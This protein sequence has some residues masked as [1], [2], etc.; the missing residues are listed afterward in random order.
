MQIESQFTIKELSPLFPK[1][2]IYFEKSQLAL[3]HRRSADFALVKPLAKAI[4]IVRDQ[5][6][7]QGAR[8]QR[9][10][11]RIHPEPLQ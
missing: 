9:T 7:G 4:T 5:S 6:H 2:R 1:R 3:T 11:Q 8:G 10:R